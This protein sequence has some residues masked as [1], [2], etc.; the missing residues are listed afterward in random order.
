MHFDRICPCCVQS[1]ESGSKIPLPPLGDGEGKD[2]DYSHTRYVKVS[3]RQMALTLA[4]T[5]HL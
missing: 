3:L 5:A 4:I 2:D 1:S